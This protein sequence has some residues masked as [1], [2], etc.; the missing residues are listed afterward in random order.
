MTWTDI[1]AWLEGNQFASGGLLVLV[2]GYLLVAFRDL[3]RLLWQGFLLQFTVVVEARNNDEAFH[4]IQDWLDEAG[5][6]RTARRVTVTTQTFRNNNGNTACMI[7]SPSP[8]L[9]WIRYSGRTMLLT[10]TRIE[11]KDTTGGAGSM[12]ASAAPE[13]FSIRTLGRSQQVIRKLMTEIQKSALTDV[14]KVKIYVPGGNFWESVV[15]EQGKALDSVVLPVG[16]VEKLLADMKHFLK[17]EDWYR[18][19]DIPYRRGYLLHGPPGNG[20][21]SIVRA[22]AG[23]FSMDIYCIALSTIELSDMGLMRL[24]SSV[25]PGNILLIEDV[26]CLLNVK[27]DN[28]EKMSGSG[29]LGK[30]L[31]DLMG[32]GNSVAGLLNMI[33][34]VIAPEGRMLFMTTNSPDSIDSALSRPGRVDF[35]LGIGNATGDQAARMF[36]R[37]FPASSVRTRRRFAESLPP[38]T[39]MATLQN[40][41]MKHYEDP[42]AAIETLSGPGLLPVSSL[43]GVTSN[44]SNESTQ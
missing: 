21:S 28:G 17:G 41:L 37:F 1:S 10:R 23:H 20:K 27:R 12:Y 30:S 18:E 6:G 35:K 11:A 13:S 2:G 43:M 24:F 31:E 5:H 19:M 33:D 40:I 34:G 39:S 32:M 26:D 38:G 22:L 29:D 16:D 9:H 8:G 7:F 36:K 42:E 3:P 4:W 25:P 15:V 14:G 44:T